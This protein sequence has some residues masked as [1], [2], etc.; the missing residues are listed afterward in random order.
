[1]GTPRLSRRVLLFG[2]GPEQAPARIR[3]LPP[4][5]DADAFATR[6]TGCN[7]CVTRCPEQVLVLREGRAEFDP[8]RGECT[9][10]GDCVDAC[11][12]GALHRENPAEQHVATVAG[13]CLPAHGVV[14]ASCRD[15]CP[16][17]AIQLSLGAR[18]AAQID[19]DACT[20]CGACVAV[21]P[22]SAVSLH[23][24]EGACA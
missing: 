14:C 24:R 13:T 19:A 9:F 8:A 21:C 6:C 15:V 10:C 1:M 7:D 4:W 3:V 16:T 23:F 20:G 17:R 11:A 5:A 18:K 22:V 12:T 2:R